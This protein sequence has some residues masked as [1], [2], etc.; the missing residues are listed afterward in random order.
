MKTKMDSFM[1]NFKE[2]IQSVFLVRTSSLEIDFR[3]LRVLTCGT[4]VLVKNYL[5]NLL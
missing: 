1:D 2:D 5:E 4:K 3:K